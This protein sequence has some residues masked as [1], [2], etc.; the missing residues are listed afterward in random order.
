MMPRIQKILYATDLSQNSAYAFRYA[1][2][3]AIEH[4]AEII[5]LHVLE[6]MSSTTQAL[7]N[8]HIGEEHIKKLLEDRTRYAID[9]INKRFKGFPAEV[10]LRTANELDCDAIVIGAHGKD[11]L[12]YTFFGST[13]KRILRRT[14]KPVFIIPLPHGEIDITFHDD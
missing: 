2:K 3:L 14:R 9:R 6:K 11:R 8:M 1:I 7:A 5:I 4:D 12:T 10:I 13:A